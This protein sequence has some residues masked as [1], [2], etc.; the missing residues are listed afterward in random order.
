MI[1][2]AFGPNGYGTYQLTW[3]EKGPSFEPVSCKPEV[4]VIPGFIDIHFHGAFGIDL[5]SA[6]SKEIL[7]LCL[8][9]E[10]EGYEGFLVTTITSTPNQVSSMIENLPDHP[11]ILGVHLE[12]PFISKLYPGAQ[13]AG[14]ILDP[15]QAGSEWENIFSY[16]NLRLI[17]FAPELSGSLELI[18]KMKTKGVLMSMGHTNA[19]YEEAEKAYTYGATHITHMFNG[20]KNFH[21]RDPGIVGYALCNPLLN[22]E[23]IY[24]RHHVSTQA[25][26]LLLQNRSI[27][28]LIG[29]SDS[30]MATGLPDGS[31]FMMW[32][33]PC[34]V[35]K[36]KVY[37]EKQK[38]LAG[39]AINM[40][41]AY[42]YFAEDF[43]DEV[44]VQICCYNPRRALGIKQ[45]PNV[46]LVLDKERKI[47][48]R[49]QLS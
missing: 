41:T 38:I 25:V 23:L 33:Q 42:R 17:T 2:A 22:L 1:A 10:E 40:L 8:K 11:M 24:D 32:G 39:S 48:E 4:W 14:A 9:L 6:S 16:P 7:R 15:L 35:E 37:L 47:L 21:H 12:G 18:Q 49:Y 5:M 27:E 19:T 36:G 29:I 34:Q 30:T 43:G 26:K 20:M 13:P 46:W 31:H 3:G 44:A 28:T 45:D